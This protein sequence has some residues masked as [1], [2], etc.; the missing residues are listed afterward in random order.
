MKSNNFMNKVSLIANKAV[1]QLKK[2]S[3]E[4]LLVGG[5][6]G[7]VASAVLA[8]KASTKVGALIDEAKNTVNNIHDIVNDPENAETYSEEDGKKAV[9]VTYVQTGLKVARLYAPAVALGTVS[10]ACIFASNNILRKRNVAIAAAYATVDAAFKDYKGRVIDL[11]GEEAERKL[12][13]NLKSQVIEETV[14]D[15][16]GEE[17]TVT[18]TVD[19]VDPNGTSMYSKI[20]D[21]TNPNW[22]RN[23]EY[24]LMFLRAQQQYANDLLKAKGRLFLN[25]V[26]SMLGFEPTKAGQIVGWVYNPDNENGDGY[27]DFGLYNIHSESAR[28]FINGL[29]PAVLLDFNVDG[30]VWDSM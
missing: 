10:I 4:I 18:K 8:C 27:V 6:I 28:N 12:R 7:V 22:E 15:E 11:I 5:T 30:N 13:L 25:E 26:Y 29:E 17:K 16:N 23:A 3:P 1:F 24:N 19:V 9:A 14:V 21:E 20:F 2:H